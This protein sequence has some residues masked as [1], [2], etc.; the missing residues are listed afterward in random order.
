MFGPFAIVKTK[1]DAESIALAND[2]DFG[3]GSNVFTKSTKRAEKLGSQLEAGMTSINDFCS[4]TWHN[5]FRSAASKSL[6]SIVSP[7]SRVSAGA[8]SPNP[9]SSTD[10]LSS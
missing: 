5:P 10:F 3:L 9:S 6:D 8:A 1:S 4:T 2:C 7:A